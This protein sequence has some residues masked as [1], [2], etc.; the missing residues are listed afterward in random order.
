MLNVNLKGTIHSM[1][2]VT[3]AMMMQEPRIVKGRNG[4]RSIGRG[5]IVNISSA[6]GYVAQAGK[7]P[8]IASKFAVIGVTKTAGRFSQ[9]ALID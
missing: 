6:N 2:A 9:C 1:G 5:S 4:E 3:R 7:G 8:Y